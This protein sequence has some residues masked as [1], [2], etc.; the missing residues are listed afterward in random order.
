M[1]KKVAIQGVKGSFH[2]LVTQNYFATAVEIE[3]F[4]TFKEAVNA[5]TEKKV[6]AAVMA[7]ENSI[8]GSII[9]NYALIDNNA[10]HIT[11]EYYLDV[12]HN[13]MALPGQSI[14]DIKEVCSHPMALLQCQAFFD[15]YPQA[16]RTLKTCV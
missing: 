14:A 2:H 13:L 1:I 9:P 16:T 12:Q 10:L 4:L 15:Q 5:L 8:A 11:G 6:E 3:P 7:L